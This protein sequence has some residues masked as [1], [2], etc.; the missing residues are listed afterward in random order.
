VA[1]LPLSTFIEQV[2]IALAIFD[3][4]FRYLAVSPAYLSDIAWLISADTFAP[5]DVIG[6]SVYETF[7]KFPERWRE[8]HSR[9]LAGEKLGAQEELVQRQDGEI[10]WVRWSAMPWHTTNGRIG[11]VPVFGEIITEEIKAK[12]ALAESEERFRATFENAAVGISH[13]TP[14][15]RFLRFNEALSRIVGWPADELITKTIGDT[16]HPD[17]LGLEFAQFK[18]VEDGRIESST[19]DKRDLRKDGTIVWIRRTVS[20]MRK[21]GSCDYFVG[22]VEDISARKRA[23]ELLRRQADLL[24]Q[25]HDAILT[26]HTGDRRIAY[27]NRGAERLYGYTAA[28][29]EGRRTDE[30]LN[31][32]AAIPIEDIDAQL[33]HGGSW[34]GELTHTTRD[35]RDIV[36][37]SRIVPVS[38]DGEMFA[39]E[40]NRDITDRKRAEDELRQSEE[41]FRSSVVQSPVPTI[42]YDD[43]EQIVAISRSWLNAAG[44]ISAAE[45]HRL[46]DWTIRA[47]GERSG[48]VLEFL[49]GVIATEP[50]AQT[51][52]FIVLTRGGDNRLWKFVDTG[53]G[54]LS[55]GRRLF[56][57]VAQ[58]ITDR[59]AYEERIEL[60][61]RE[62]H[63]RGKN[64]LGL[65]QAVARQTAAR[66][67]EHFVASFTER[68]QALAANH[69]LLIESQW[70][71]ADVEDLVRVQLA[72][73]ADLVGSRIAVHGP[74]LR[75]NAAAPRRSAWQFTNLRQMP[76]NTAR[77]RPITGEST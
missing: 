60:L 45:L 29:A 48:D 28:E 18:Q 3:A 4:D 11:G 71:G 41:R 56:V 74:K 16:T 67:P 73:F 44:D 22:V 66:E 62:S 2:P 75:L 68:V 19:I 70:Q 46:E 8:V 72:H 23:E 58:D 42:L 15:G 77:S 14:D 59:R 17:D 57:S 53:L 52:E 50:E 35:G 6:R 31:T 33:V 49:R 38:Y 9:A 34:Y 39:L 25:S 64:I 20:C 54:T 30:L 27:W 7:P 21:S 65:V 36:V 13:V 24:D 32:R 55:D 10:E 69:D 37:E 63:H 5:A 1:P 76:T 51:S 26:M 40:T 61:M 12:H 43:R 47:Y